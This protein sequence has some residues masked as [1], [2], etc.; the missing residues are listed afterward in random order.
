VLPAHSRGTELVQGMQFRYTPAYITL[1][2]ANTQ[3]WNTQLTVPFQRN[4]DSQVRFGDLYLSAFD[5]GNL[6]LKGTD[7]A[8]FWAHSVV[9]GY[10]A[11]PSDDGEPELEFP[12]MGETPKQLNLIINGA[13]SFGFSVVWLE[14][15]RDSVFGEYPKRR[16]SDPLPAHF[17]D[18]VRAT[19]L[20]QSY[21][22]SIYGVMAHEIGH[23]PGKQWA[24]TDHAEGG[25]MRRGAAN[26]TEE[27][28]RPKTIK[29]F[30]SVTSWS[31]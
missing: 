10:Q 26:I 29:R 3:S 20:Q 7:R 27:S 17:M 8:G 14:G 18:S 22:Y 31:Q 13:D 1:I 12:D 25:L 9:F 16:A 2:N 30:R 21:T 5:T 24:F 4:A 11:G 6:Q 19:S 23:A 28:F 15:I